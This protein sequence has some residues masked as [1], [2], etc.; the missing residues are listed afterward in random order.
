METRKNNW[1]KTLPLFSLLCNFS[2]GNKTVDF[3]LMTPKHRGSWCLS[4]AWYVHFHFV[5]LFHSQHNFQCAWSYVVRQ[6]GGQ[7]DDK[8]DCPLEPAACPSTSLPPCGPRQVASINFQKTRR[9]GRSLCSDRYIAAASSP[10]TLCC[11]TSRLREGGEG[12]A[13]VKERVGV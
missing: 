9:L 2:Q 7:A 11:A 5:S 12:G 4:K 13:G 1:V 3:T 10:T 6:T 8:N